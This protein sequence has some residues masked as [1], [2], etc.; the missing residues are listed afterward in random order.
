MIYDGVNRIYVTGEYNSGRK[1]LISSIIHKFVSDVG[2]SDGNKWEM[3]AI[4]KNTE[5]LRGGELIHASI[6]SY[7][8]I[9][10]FAIEK[11]AEDSL[12]KIP[13]SVELSLKINN[14]LC[15]KVRFVNISDKADN[16]QIFSKYFFPVILVVIDSVRIKDKDENYILRTYENLEKLMNNSK[17]NPGVVFALTKA[18][19]L[20]EQFKKND[21]LELYSLFDKSELVSYCIKNTIIYKTRAVSALNEHTEKVFDKNGNFLDNPDFEPWETDKL[22]FDIISLSVPLLHNQVKNIINNCNDIIR[23][24]KGIFNDGNVRAYL[25]LINARK[26]LCNITVNMYTLDNAIK[27]IK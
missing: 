9:K 20:P 18:D 27:Y 2:W 14:E 3:S 11:V 1:T 17:V 25:E 7:E 19:L 10:K 24:R 26:K 4:V 12:Y 22:F 5:T 23:R 8:K 16:I 15:G 13:D 6:D 21:F